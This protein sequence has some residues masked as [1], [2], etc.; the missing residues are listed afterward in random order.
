MEIKRTIE[1]SVEKTCRFVICQPE[2]DETLSCPA[3]GELMLTWLKV[4]HRSKMLA[5]FGILIM[6]RFT[7]QNG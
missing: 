4:C 7:T 5:G 6:R 2:A 3:C 1:I